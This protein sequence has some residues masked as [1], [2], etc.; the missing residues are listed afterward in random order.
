VSNEKKTIKKNEIF[1][2]IKSDI[3][4]G[5]FL[6]ASMS[7]CSE[8]VGLNLAE[9]GW[10]QPIFSNR[11]GRTP[12][13]D[14]E[15]RLGATRCTWKKSAQFFAFPYITERNEWALLSLLHLNSKVV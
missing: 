15:S 2:K 1:C 6:K 11:Q 5:M 12:V 13:A 14:Q 7:A 10:V 8:K 4:C 9:T 3:S